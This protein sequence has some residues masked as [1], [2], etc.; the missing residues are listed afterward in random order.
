VITSSQRLF[1]T[2]HRKRMAQWALLKLNYLTWFLFQIIYIPIQH[3]LNSFNIYGVQCDNM[4]MNQC[5]MIIYEQLMYPSSQTFIISLYW[6]YSRFSQ[7]LFLNIHWNVNHSHPPVLYN[8]RNHS[9]CPTAL[10]KPLA[11][12]SSVPSRYRFYQDSIHL[13]MDLC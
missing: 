4:K 2:V 13:R 5:V 10:L 6:E 7:W 3:I 1:M 11:I 9:S 8:I 12:L